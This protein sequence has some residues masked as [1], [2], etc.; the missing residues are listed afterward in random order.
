MFE[1]ASS[2]TQSYY[3]S[4]FQYAEDIGMC[5]LGVKDNLNLSVTNIPNEDI[6]IHINPNKIQ[7]N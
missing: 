7:G 2:C 3:C 4:A 5:N 1:C 6:S